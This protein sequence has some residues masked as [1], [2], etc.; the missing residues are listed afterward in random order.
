[1]KFA[2]AIATVA[3]NQYDFIFKELT[4]VYKTFSKGNSPSP[5]TFQDTCVCFGK[6]VYKINF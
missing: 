3:A 6:P 4:K 2:L 5:V 1:M